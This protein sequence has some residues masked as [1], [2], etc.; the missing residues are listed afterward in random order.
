[1]QLSHVV[2]PFGEVN[3]YPQTDGSTYVVVSILMEPNR[4]GVQTGLAIDGSGSMRKA[5]GVTG[6]VSSIFA[7]ATPNYVKPVAQQMSSYLANKVDADGSVTVIYWAVGPGGAQVEEVGDLKAQIAETYD[8][9][10]PNLW[11]TGTQLLPAVKYFVDRFTS[12]EWG[13]YIFI[14]DGIVDDMDQVKAYSEKLAQDID[15]G[16]HYPVKLVLI[17]LGE[18]VDEAQ[19]SELDDLD[20]GD[21]DLWDHKMALEM[22]NLAEIFAEAVDENARVADHGIIKDSS[23]KVVKNY[24]DTG[25]PALLKFT[26]PAGA[27]SFTLEVAG[28]SIIQSLQ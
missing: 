8:F 20:T 7:S 21:I 6:M 2:E 9:K 26:L 24:S 12:N 18:E 5:F 1:M 17:G 19:L 4:E 28:Q 3:V 15:V 13:I 10:G 14:T 23:G 27:T 22:K 11:G 16:R 25:L